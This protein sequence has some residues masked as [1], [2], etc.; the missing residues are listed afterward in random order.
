L[1]CYGVGN[2]ASAL[3]SHRELKRLDVVDI[4]P[5]V[6]ALAKHFAAA[7]GDNPLRDPRTHVFVDDGRHHLITHDARYDV[8][9]AEPPPPN[10]AG[11]VNLYSREFYRL[12]KQRLAAGGVITQWLPVFQL[13]DSDVRAMIAAFVAELPHTALLYGYGQQLILIGALQPLVMQIGAVRDDDALSRNLRKNAIGTIEDVLGSVLQTD[14][15]LRREVAGVSAL[16]DE[17]PTIQYPYETVSDRALYTSRFVPNPRRALL[18]LGGRADADLQARVLDAWNAT[19]SAL[20]AL[21]WVESAPPEAREL[22]LGRRLQPALDARPAN[23]GTWTLLSAERDR[24]ALAELALKRPGALDLVAQPRRQV[25]KSAALARY[26]VLQDALWLLARRA[27]YAHDY[28]HALAW[29]QK[30]T[31]AADQAASYALLRAG[32]LRGLGEFAASSEAFRTAAAASGD[33]SFR[34]ACAA[35]AERAAQ[36]FARS[37]GPWSLDAPP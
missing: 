34:R 12:A 5:E 25:E 35:L 21:P 6:L 23:E 31:P 17:R 32:S 19:E 36:P 13:A 15:E 9:T 18:L 28:A 16:S 7:R 29:L 30:H 1:I 4:S 11:V 2:T 8:I 10:Y 27:F 20:S 24:V 26:L 14:A 22:A 37:A 33:A 3:L